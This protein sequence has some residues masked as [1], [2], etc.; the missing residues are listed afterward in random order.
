M[1]LPGVQ[2]TGPLRSRSRIAGGHRPS[3]AKERSPIPNLTSSTPRAVVHTSP[4]GGQ[5]SPKTL[6]RLSS[7]FRLPC[8][9][10]ECHDTRYVLRADRP[11]ATFSWS[12]PPTDI[13]ASGPPADIDQSPLRGLQRVRICWQLPQRYAKLSRE[14][15]PVRQEPTLHRA[16]RNSK[17][18]TPGQGLPAKK[19][20][21][22]FG[23]T[24]SIVVKVA[25]DQP[26]HV[27]TRTVELRDPRIQVRRTRS[28]DDRMRLQSHQRDQTL[29]DRNVGVSLDG[30]V[31][32]VH[33][34]NSWPER[35]STC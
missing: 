32:E 7:S 12:H 25:Q 28:C 11:P 9:A 29:G 30:E 2:A 21:N 31:D 22:Q 16:D 27:L 24:K 26:V 18:N 19:V 35:S 14:A 20:R 5:G 1:V 10:G 15:L 33:W 3:L 34:R 13:G 17:G 23:R 6:R 4:Q 8:E